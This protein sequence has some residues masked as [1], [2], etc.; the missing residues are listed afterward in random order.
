LLAPTELLVNVAA[1]GEHPAGAF[2]VKEAVG[3]GNTMTVVVLV[4]VQ[5]AGVLAV[6]LT[7]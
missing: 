1:T 6:K 7:V 5:L 2:N 4:S 3:F